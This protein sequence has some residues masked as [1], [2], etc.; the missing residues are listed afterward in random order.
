MFLLLL[1][2]VRFVVCIVCVV[3]CVSVRCLCVWVIEKEMRVREIEEGGGSGSVG[4]GI[5][6]GVRVCVCV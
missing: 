1:W 4:E 6:R 5:D 2:C 3:S